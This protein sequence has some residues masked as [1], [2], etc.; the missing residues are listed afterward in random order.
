[1][2]DGPNDVVTYEGYDDSIIYSRVQL[3]SFVI[4]D[5][6]SN[7]AIIMYHDSNLKESQNTLYEFEK[8]LKEHNF[9]YTKEIIIE[10]DKE[11]IYNYMRYLPFCPELVIYKIQKV[12]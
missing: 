2:I 9:N 1:M 12:A 7:N 11:I 6:L 5:K 8:L 3:L 4:L 10:M